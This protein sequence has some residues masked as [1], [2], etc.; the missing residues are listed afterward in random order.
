[1]KITGKACWLFLLAV[2][3]IA[4]LSPRPTLAQRE[5]VRLSLWL[6]DGGYRCEARSGQDNSFFL[7]VRNTGTKPIT[8]IRLS[9]DKP[10]GWVVEFK[11]AEIDYLG[12]GSVQTVDVNIKPVDK[13]AKATKAE[14][15]VPFIAEANEIRMVQTISIMVKPAQFWIW[16][17]IVAGV[18][19][20]AGFVLLYLRFGRQ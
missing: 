3:L 5:G 11:P 18:V 1:M 16:V 14:Y 20:V 2:G 13:A 6:R 7:E 10:E 4:I 9:S 19:V 15:K 17:W 8:N 12:S